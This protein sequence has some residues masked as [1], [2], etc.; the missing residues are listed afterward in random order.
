MP[1]L[2]VWWKDN[3]NPSITETLT[4]GGTA[5]DLT[6][7]TVKFKMRELGSSTLT[8]DAAAVVVSAAAGTVRYDW[9]S[10][11]VDTAGK[12]LVW[13]EV[14]TSSK[15]QDMG[16]A[17]IE[18]RAHAPLSNGYVELEDFKLE[19]RLAPYDELPAAAEAAPGGGR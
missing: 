12:F 18:I 16:E 7:S 19:G 5:F 8:V 3:R 9:A 2:L 1:N 13:W 6:S 4:V 11:D 10:G 15:T 17:V 14:T